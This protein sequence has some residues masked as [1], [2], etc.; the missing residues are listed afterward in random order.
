MV[1]RI[2]EA[3]CHHPPQHVPPRDRGLFQIACLS[4]SPLLNHQKNQWIRESRRETLCFVC[5][6]SSFSSL[7]F[8]PSFL[9]LSHEHTLSTTEDGIVVPRRVHVLIPGTVTWL[10]SMAK[11][12]KGEHS[13]SQSQSQ[14]R[15]RCDDK[16]ERDL[17]MLPC[18]L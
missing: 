12:I 13:R 4:R 8:L 18:R 7:P 10:P 9:Y 2:T 3:P 11:V 1:K 17:K 16:A 14:R 5:I 15:K 6:F